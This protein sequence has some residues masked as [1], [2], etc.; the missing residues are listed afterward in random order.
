MKQCKVSQN[1]LRS[2]FASSST[3][4]RSMHVLSQFKRRISDVPVL[5]LD[6]EVLV[7]NK[8]S[9]FICDYDPKV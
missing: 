9:G 1:M 6:K 8:P 2:R 7:I 3:A 4:T 5:Y